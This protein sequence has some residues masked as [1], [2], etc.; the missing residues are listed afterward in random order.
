MLSGT[1]QMR[2]EISQRPAARS[3]RLPRR[4]P[5]LDSPLLTL[6][7]DEIAK[8]QPGQEVFLDR[9]LDLLLIATLRAWFLPSR[10][11]RARLVPGRTATRSVVC[12]R[13][14]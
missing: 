2:G 14:P 4:A 10:G 9:L 8:D 12:G 5:P 11:G 1:Y 3:A 7:G 13:A 6:L